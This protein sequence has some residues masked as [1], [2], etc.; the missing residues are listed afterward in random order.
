MPTRHWTYSDPDPE[1]LERCL[2]A[3]AAH[4]DQVALKRGT[5]NRRICRAYFTPEGERGIELHCGDGL[6]ARY[7]VTPERVTLLPERAEQV[8][9]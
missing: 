1:D 8:G 5:P 2:D 3:W 4:C 6:L 7:S 9:Q